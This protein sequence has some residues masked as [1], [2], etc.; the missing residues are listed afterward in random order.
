MNRYVVGLMF[1]DDMTKVCMIRK[2]RPDW[3]KGLLNGIGGKIDGRETPLEAMIREFREET[4]VD[5]KARAWAHVCTLRF[6]YAEIEYFAG[7][8]S[9][10]CSSVK[11]TTDEPIGV[12]RTARGVLKEDV[13]YPLVENIPMLLELSRQRLVDREGLAPAAMV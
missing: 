11:T 4:G 8:D 9:A 10:V 7:K 1:N 2:N 6:P 13:F 5:T 12:Y 3:Q